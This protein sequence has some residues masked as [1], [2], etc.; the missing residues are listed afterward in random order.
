M[1]Y[2]SL[3]TNGQGEIRT[4]W[5]V[6]DGPDHLIYASWVV[7]NEPERWAPLC[8]RT[9]QVRGTALENTE[10]GIDPWSRTPAALL[11]D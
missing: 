5:E 6:G 3:W 9:Y 10:C 2:V 8:G 4:N 11:L 7:P 1:N